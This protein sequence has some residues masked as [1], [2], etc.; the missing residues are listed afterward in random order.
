MRLKQKVYLARYM[1]Q[2]V[3]EWEHREVVE[4]QAY[5]AAM[6]E[7]IK[8]ENELSRAGEDR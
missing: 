2:D 8:G 7:L 1:R 6:S 5:F 3:F 4:L